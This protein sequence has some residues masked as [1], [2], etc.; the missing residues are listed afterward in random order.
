MKQLTQLSVLLSLFITGPLGAQESPYAGL[1]K[2]DIKALSPEQIE[3]YLAG[4]G[5]GFAL[6]AELNGFP[7]PRHVLDLADSLALNDQQRQETQ[8]V[9]EGMLASA[10]RLGGELVAEERI[11]DS[12]FAAQQIT[13]ESLH[14][15]VTKLGQLQAELRYVHLRAHL[16]MAQILSPAQAQRYQHLRGYT[17]GHDHRMRQGSID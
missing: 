15:S 5:S 6:A 3:A 7:G 17:A 12:L 4:E 14:A 8:A 16:T 1:E 2:R 9:F 11:L 13:P 10:K